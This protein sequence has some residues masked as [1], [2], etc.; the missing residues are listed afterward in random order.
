MRRLILQLSTLALATLAAVSSHA[1]GSFAVPIDQSAR[2]P[3][4]AGA[5]HVMIGN[6]AIADINVLDA[7][8]VVILGRTYGV[9]NLL[10]LDARGRTLADQQIVVSAAE[11]N[12][13]SV[14][15]GDPLRQSGDGGPRV[16][17]L[18]CSPRCEHTPMP[19][20]P[21]TPYDRYNTAFTSYNER[22]TTGRTTA[23]AA[24]SGP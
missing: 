19:G 11:V 18:A 23:G 24:K 1:A 2:F 20:E 5:Q 10:V 3:L 13:V 6:P 22:A 12:R 7:R 15:R 4:P 21:Q 14:Y 16:E 8:N 9:T 17:N